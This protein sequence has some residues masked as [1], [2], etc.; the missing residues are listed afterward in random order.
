MVGIFQFAMLVTRG[1]P[2]QIGE[3]MVLEA[4]DSTCEPL[5]FQPMMNHHRYSIDI[6]ITIEI[7]RYCVDSPIFC[8]LILYEKSPWILYNILYNCIYTYS[9]SQKTQ[10]IRISPSAR[11]SWSFVWK[12]LLCYPKSMDIPYCISRMIDIPGYSTV[13]PYI[14][15]YL[16][17]KEKLIWIWSYVYIYN[18]YIYL[19]FHIYLT[20]N[21]FFTV[22][23]WR[24]LPG[25]STTWGPPRCAWAKC[26]RRWATSTAPP[27]GAAGA[28]AGWTWPWWST[29]P[30]CALEGGKCQKRWK[31]GRKHRGKLWKIRGTWGFLWD[32]DGISP[33][34]RG[35]DQWIMET[36]VSN[37]YSKLT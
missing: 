17:R 30:W 7:Y 24:S 26:C 13:F 22:Y 36:W 15:T 1:Y 35:F 25:N 37:S 10:T 27:R 18:I 33:A 31:M 3:V 4:V 28:A 34:K 2:D 20:K 19:I 11:C 21:T 29:A 9:S 23:R 8:P 16:K 5:R 6:P 14:Y 12:T 32:L